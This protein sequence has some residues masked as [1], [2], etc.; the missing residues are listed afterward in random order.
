L[1]FSVDEIDDESAFIQWGQS[2]ERE[3][4]HLHMEP[5]KD[6]GL[7]EFPEEYCIMAFELILDAKH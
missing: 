6:S 3:V 2:F 5:I 4:A 1:R 7:I